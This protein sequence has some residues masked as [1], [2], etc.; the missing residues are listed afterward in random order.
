MK[1][2]STII[3]G[4][5]IAGSLVLG[6]T[7]P[8]DAQHARVLAGLNGPSFAIRPEAVQLHIGGYYHP[9]VYTGIG[10]VVP[11]LPLGYSSFYWGTLPFYYYD[12]VFYQSYAGGG[13]I[14]AAP[15][16]GAEIA[17]IPL[18]AEI[19]TID[20]NLY[21]EYK[22]VYYKSV[23]HTDG[24]IV[25][26][27][28]GTD[29]VQNTKIQPGTA[30]PFIGDM[31]DRLPDGTQPVTLNNKTYWVTPE[32]VYLE[33]VRKDEKVTYRVV[34]VPEKKFDKTHPA[35]DNKQL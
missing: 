9:Y 21:Y 3:R 16:V 2:M 20:G 11:V 29:G 12:G 31:T 15:P 19:I 7:A 22:G 34:W 10:V 32:G 28:V 33:E 6:L 1:T 24:R 4:F 23:I 5:C 30:L 25:Y 18:N 27:V 17:S 26:Q 8:A 35:G 13:Y 14:I